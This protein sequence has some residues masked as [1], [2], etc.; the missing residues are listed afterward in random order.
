MRLPLVFKSCRGFLLAACLAV[1]GSCTRDPYETGDNGNSYLRADFTDAHSMGNGKIDYA[2]KDNNEKLR[3]RTP[4]SAAWAQE[5]D[6]FHRALFYYHDRR[7]NIEPVAFVRIPTVNYREPEAFTSGIK[8]DPVIFRSAWMSKNHKYLNLS[9]G[10]KDGKSDNENAKHVLGMV[11]DSIRLDE[12]GKPIL[13]LRLFHDQNNV[14]EY[15][16][17]NRYISVIVGREYP[18]LEIRL[19]IKTYEGWIEKRLTY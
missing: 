3:L 7:E 4:F 5:P 13:Y 9:L 12:N 8:T 1:C 14:P 19:S 16:F 15:Y 10:L 17:Q 2:V 6:K 11:R 18:Q